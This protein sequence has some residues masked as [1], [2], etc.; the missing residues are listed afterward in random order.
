MFN[1]TGAKPGDI[2]LLVIDVHLREMRDAVK[3]MK[4]PSQAA[5]FN[6]HLQGMEALAER[7]RRWLS[8]EP[9]PGKDAEAEEIKRTLKSLMESLDVVAGK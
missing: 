6:A 8:M 9:G 7:N 2:N 1:L 5:F 3:E 4:D